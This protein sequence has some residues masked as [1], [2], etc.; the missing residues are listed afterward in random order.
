MLVNSNSSPSERAKHVNTSV[1]LIS[2]FP[3]RSESD[4]T[5][6]A[7]AGPSPSEYPNLQ[8]QVTVLTSS[9]S[10]EALRIAV[11]KVLADLVFLL[12]FLSLVKACPP[13]ADGIREMRSILDT[14]RGEACSLVTFIENHAMRL[15]KLDEVLQEALDGTAFAINHE[16]RRIFESELADA[17]LGLAEQEI[18]ESLLYAQGV[19]TNCFQ[20]SMINL[21]RV[22]DN[23]VTGARL[24]QDWQTR[25]ERSLVLCRDLS[26]LICLVQASEQEPLDCLANQLRSFREGSMQWLIYRDWKEYEALSERII[27]SL[28][29]RENP[30]DLLHQLSCY[31]ETLLAHVKA[32]AV[33]ADLS[34]EPFGVQEALSVS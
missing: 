9:I 30:A 4:L 21:A 31:L 22:F 23:S 16:V 20:Q 25:R 17:Q 11:E 7:N 33:L 32:R 28:R 15:E 19:L 3:V 18:Q 29:N 2:Q 24:F 5:K 14:V 26:A 1:S 13:D 8:S 12:D 27:L 6:S 10:D 34:L